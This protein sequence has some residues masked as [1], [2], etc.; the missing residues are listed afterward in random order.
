VCITLSGPDASS[1]GSSVDAAQVDAGNSIVDAAAPDADAT[2]NSICDSTKPFGMPVLVSGLETQESYSARLSADELT[3][4]YVIQ[5]ATNGTDIY[6]ATRSLADASFVSNGPMPAVNSAADEYW[7][8][9]SADGLLVFFESS[10]TLTP[11]DAGVY[12]DDQ[13]RIWSSSRVDV[14]TDFNP[15]RIDTIFVDGGTEGAPY[16]HPAKASLYFASGSR[17]GAGDIDLF[18]ATTNASGVVTSINNITAVNSAVEEN[19]PVVSADE[20]ELYFGRPDQGDNDTTRNIWVS[21]RTQKTGQF[22]PPALL[23]ELNTTNDEYPSFVSADGCRLFFISN[24]PI[25]SD[26]VDAG[27]IPYRIWVAAR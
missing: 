13:A 11:D 10:R 2:A 14:R 1:D 5:T 4:F 27:P 25:A 12:Q 9:L 22:G 15:P 26:P 6:Q 23:T 16:L 20:L 21:R 8:T 18:V 7:P 17:G 3:M 24:R 19:M